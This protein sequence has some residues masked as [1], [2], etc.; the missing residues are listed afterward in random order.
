M[1]ILTLNFLTC[2]VKAC[3]SSSA[4]FPLHP[5]DAELVQDNLELN[6]KLLV[7]IL[8]RIDWAALIT[9]SAEVCHPLSPFSARRI[10]LTL[11]HSGRNTTDRP[12]CT[13]RIPRPAGQPTHAG[14]TS[15]RREDAAGVASV[16]DGDADERGEAGVWELWA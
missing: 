12:R 16:V 3:K 7:N 2:A 11:P 5:K 4:S 6:P 14:G 8:P 10:S 9:T 13:V 15:R 1:K